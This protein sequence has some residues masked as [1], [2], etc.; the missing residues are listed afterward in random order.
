MICLVYG[1][2]YLLFA[3]NSSNFKSMLTKLLNFHLSL[4]K[5]NGV[6]GFLGVQVAVNS[7][8]GSVKFT[9]TGLFDRKLLQ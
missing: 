2:D 3:H 4:Q 6:T 7:K 5:E 8:N 1:D 9:Q